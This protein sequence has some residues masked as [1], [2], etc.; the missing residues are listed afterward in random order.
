MEGSII[1][2]AGSLDDLLNLIKNKGNLCVLDFFGSWC[3]PCQRL[4]QILP[5]IS[6]SNPD[7]AFIK[8]DIDKNPEVANNYAISSVP[9]IFFVKYEQ[10]EV[11]VLSTVIGCFPDGI[12]ANIAN[13]R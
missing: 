1:N 4:G 10:N 8:I 5:S 9:H 13:L 2:F 7:V 3:P 12:K 6:A 11:Q